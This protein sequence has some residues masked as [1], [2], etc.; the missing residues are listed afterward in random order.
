M[1]ASWVCL[2]AYLREGVRLGDREREGGNRAGNQ[3]GGWTLS[4]E[5]WEIG[6]GKNFRQGQ[7]GI[8]GEP[9][10]EVHTQEAPKTMC[11][12]PDGDLGKPFRV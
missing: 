1:G 5:C 8:K 9:L 2:T 7:R 3:G 6:R 10:G 12:F 11:C 4:L